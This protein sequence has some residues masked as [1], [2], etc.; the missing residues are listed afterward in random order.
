MG[1]RSFM[2]ATRMPM[3]RGGF[4]E[5]LRTPLPVLDIILNPSA[6]YAG[7]ASDGV[8]PDWDLTAIADYPAASAAI[9][10]DRGK[11]PLQLL[12]A[13]AAQGF[14]LVRHHDDALEAYLYDYHGDP[15]SAQ[16]E[17]LML[18][19][20]GRFAHGDIETPVMYWGGDVYPDLPLG[21]DP[22]LAVMVVGNTRAWFVGNYPIDTLIADLRSVE[23]DFLAAAVDQG[24]EGFRW[25]S[26]EVLDPAVRAH[27]L[28]P[29]AEHR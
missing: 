19:G 13:R 3:S 17:L 25:D 4:D 1:G 7:W 26:S 16:T 11:T 29:P 23:T 21:G 9:R 22:P 6:M 5:W 27:V 8:D 24:D 15:Y 10:A 18:A 14:T 20:A 28:A 12:A 2:L